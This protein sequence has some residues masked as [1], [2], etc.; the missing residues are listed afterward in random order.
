MKKITLKKLIN[1]KGSSLVM[2]LIVVSFISIISLAIMTMALSLYRIIGM[3]GRSKNAFYNAD[4]AMDEIKVGVSEVAYAE[5]GS[6]YT[7][8]VDNLLE[9]SGDLVTLIENEKANKELRNKYFEYTCCKLLSSSY[10]SADDVK[11]KVLR[12]FSSGGEIEDANLTELATYLKSFL[13][14]G[15]NSPSSSTV[16][17][18][19]VNNLPF[20]KVSSGVVTSVAIKD[21][22]II[23]QNTATDYF[24]EVSSDIVIVFPEDD[25]LRIVPATNDILMSFKD[26]ALVS[27]DVVTVVN[28]VTVNG[29]VYGQ[30]MIYARAWGNYDDDSYDSTLDTMAANAFTVS[31]GNIVTN[32][33]L[34]KNKSVLTFTNGKLWA[35]NVVIKGATATFANNSSL[36]VADD[37]TLD[38]H[39]STTKNNSVT[40]NGNYYGYS[41]EGQGIANGNTDH[42][43]SSAIIINSKDSKLNLS[44]IK[45]LILGGYG[46]VRYNSSTN[47]YYRTGES[48]AVRYAQTAYMLPSAWSGTVDPSF[49]GSSLLESSAPVITNYVSDLRGT[50]YYFNFSSGDAAA[51]FY[52]A[53]YDDSIYRTLCT[54]A[55]LDPNDDSVKEIRAYFRNILDGAYKEFLGSNPADFAIKINP[56]ARVYEKGIIRDNSSNI[57]SYN[58]VEDAFVM[59]LYANSKWRYNIINSTLIEL[60]DDWNYI[61]SE[62]TPVQAHD[63]IMYDS[64]RFSYK[65]KNANVLTKGAVENIVLGK[66]KI[67]GIYYHY[68]QDSTTGVNV[69]DYMV[70]VSNMN[71]NIDSSFPCKKGIIIC[72]GNVNVSCDFTGCILAFGDINVTGDKTYT[73]NPELVESIL[74]NVPGVRGYF[75]GVSSVEPGRHTVYNVGIAPGEEVLPGADELN[76]YKAEDC[77]KIEGYQ[78]NGT[79]H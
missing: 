79:I 29:G 39:P 25:E 15:F 9:V 33:L 6:A 49:F 47:S 42:S 40:I 46:W 11:T 59:T 64:M 44:S 56:L 30:N 3:E 41:I 57:N 63:P 24:S 31:N 10:S 74:R 7:Y 34:I 37:L 28:N 45:T 14:S 53:L 26:Y 1:D 4:M 71:C 16:V 61:A 75:D 2:A 20:V 19:T 55:V 65:I 22:Q 36:Y 21:V 69:T 77:I 43:K 67:D 58:G 76:I 13:S 62:W 72:T 27:D 48:I 38:V 54:A 12:A 18:V 51:T 78:K 66:D 50:E 73:A 17:S 5:L 68:I 60:S 23:Y 8:V 35:D 70:Y 52:K 32:R